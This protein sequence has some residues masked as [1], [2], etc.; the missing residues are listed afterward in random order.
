MQIVAT[1]ILQTD[2]TTTDKA[3]V[4]LVIADTPVEP[5][6]Q[7]EHIIAQVEIDVTPGQPLGLLQSRVLRKVTGILHPLETAIERVARQVP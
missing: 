4:R 3:T 7:P 1:F 6:A 5:T 2:P